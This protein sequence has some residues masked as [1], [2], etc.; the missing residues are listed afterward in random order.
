MRLDVEVKDESVTGRYAQAIFGINTGEPVPEDP[1]SD[2]DSLI[3]EPAAL[4]SY[5]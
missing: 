1:P 2:N 3:E 4:I 5:N